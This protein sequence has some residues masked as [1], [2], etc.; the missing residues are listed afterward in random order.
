MGDVV[1]G[2]DPAIARLA[3]GQAGAVGRSQLTALGLGR[4]AIDH[5]IER[6]RFHRRHRGAY[7]VGHD[8]PAEHADYTVAVLACGEGA[9]LGRRSALERYGVVERRAGDVHVT[10]IA[11]RRRSRPGIRVHTTRNADPRDFGS[12]DGLP[13]TSPARSLLDFA[14]DATPNELARA[15]NEAQVQNLAT[16]TEL[17]AL[18]K[19]SPGRKGAAILT[20]TLDRH[21]GPTTAHEGGEQLLEPL[22]RRARLPKPAVNAPLLGYEVDFLWEQH[23]LVIECDSGK[24]HGTPAAVDRDR[25][26]DAHLRRNGYTVLRYSFWQIA[27]EPEAVIAEIAAHLASAR[28]VV[29]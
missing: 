19:R 1:Q 17:R 18:L 13:I 11:R 8:I 6:R 9:Y 29:Q 4:G 2:A 7:L 10:V 21:D 3:G 12:I 24:F 25:R 22:L 26:K 5:R 23:K 20:A 16:P 28:A 15:V 27:D 14:D